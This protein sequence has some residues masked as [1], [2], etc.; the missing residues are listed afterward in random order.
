MKKLIPILLIILT[1]LC[2]CDSGSNKEKTPKLSKSI[3]DMEVMLD[4]KVI[5]LTDKLS[6][7]DLEKMG[8]T[9]TRDYKSALEETLAPSKDI[10]SLKN[11]SVNMETKGKKIFTVSAVNLGDKD[12]KVKDCTIYFISSG[13]AEE[14][15][16]TYSLPSKVAYN[17]TD[18]EIIKKIGKPN[19][20]L[21]DVDF[22][23]MMQYLFDN[24]TF[25]ANLDNDM[26]MNA[27]SYSLNEK[28]LFG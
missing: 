23:K 7:G 22:G 8:F 15:D 2:G 17:D 4:N 16:H 20:D 26:K 18:K 14:Y 13:S 27:F 11:V 6:F 12:K 19:I 9:P 10:N 28:I 24:G 1:L 3:G 5:S 21:R 25:T